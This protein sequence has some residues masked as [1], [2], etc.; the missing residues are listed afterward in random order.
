MTQP[1]PEVPPFPELLT[2]AEFSAGTRGKIAA[3]DPRL[4]LLLAGATAG[5][6]R[7]CRWHIAPV[8]EQTFRLDGPGG[9]VLALPTMHLVEVLSLTERGT[10]LVEDTD[11]E[12]SEV[13]SVARLG[14]ARWTERYRAII[15]TIR[16]GYETA[17]DVRQI[18][19]QVVANAL[20][21]PLGA[22]TE[23]AGG[24]AVTWAQ[25]APGV[26]GGMSL[27]ERDLAVLNTYRLGP[28]A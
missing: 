20:A 4:P 15:A 11:F 9:T 17:D 10:A 21:S 5:V 16:H 6:R 13:G 2:A 23:S 19:Q 12:W 18:I 24:V 27:L 7:Y 25:T 8:V 3:D 1:I 26:A 22:T 14:R 28:E